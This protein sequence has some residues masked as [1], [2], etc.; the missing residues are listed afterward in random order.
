MSSLLV[1]LRVRV[2][3]IPDMQKETWCRNASH[4]KGDLVQECFTC[5]RRL[6]AGIPDMQETTWWWRVKLKQVGSWVMTLMSL[7]LPPSPSWHHGSRGAHLETP[8]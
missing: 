7:S 5:T 2:V 8:K 6:D 3:G 4:A 1:P